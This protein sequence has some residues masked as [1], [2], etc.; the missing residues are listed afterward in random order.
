MDWYLEQAMER[1]R[2]RLDE[3]ET[4]RLRHELRASVPAQPGVRE[5]ALVLMGGWLVTVGRRLEVSGGCAH[6]TMAADAAEQR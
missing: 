3:A 6:P 5:R 2:A 4:A 1:T